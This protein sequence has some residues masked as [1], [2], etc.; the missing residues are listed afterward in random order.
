MS[1]LP[2]RVVKVG[3]SLLARGDLGKRL[4]AWLAKQPAAVHVLI[5][6]GGELTDVVRGWDKRHGLGEEQCHWLCIHSLS[7]TSSVL[8]AL[9]GDSAPVGNWSQ[10][11]HRI[12][13][14]HDELRPI[15]LVFDLQDFLA[16]H[17]PQLLQPVPHHWDVTTD[18]LAARLAEVL[19][20]DELVLLKSV[21]RSDPSLTVT[22]LAIAGYVDSYFPIIAVRL[23]MVSFATLDD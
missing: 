22:E 18:S 2:L 12:A 9:I 15:E 8:A 7:I 10:L 3:G 1:R 6:G 21:P 19:E 14:A 4:N 5:A 17:E 13:R 16:N 23:P 20:A 11:Q